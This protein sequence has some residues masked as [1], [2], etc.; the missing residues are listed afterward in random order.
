MGGLN[1]IIYLMGRTLEAAS[2]LP[3][4]TGYIRRTHIPEPYRVIYYYVGIK[5]GLYVL[6][7]ISRA[8]VRNNIYIFHITTVTSV[9]VFGYF[10][11]RCTNS[12]TIKKVIKM[13]I[14]VFLIIAV[15]DAVF[16]NKIFINVNSYSQGFGSL[17]LVSAAMYHIFILSQSELL[18]DKQPGFFFSIA[19]LLYFSYSIVTYVV[20]NIIYNSGYDKA[21]T[22]QLDRL[23][24]APDA[25]LYAVH[26]GLLAWMFSFFP[27][28]VNPR[29]A[30]PYWLHYSRWKKPSYKLLGNKIL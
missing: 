21:T 30:L 15:I 23:I 9:V 16:L 5:V 11:A 17:I 24:S 18:L 8:T 7:I 22:I 3:F 19:V 10:Y 13:L 27:L 20:S 2:I 28:C 1:D 14:L 12:D 26:M 29:Q 25:L 4:M 6:D